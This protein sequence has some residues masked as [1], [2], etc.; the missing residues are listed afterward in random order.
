MMGQWWRGGV[1]R[2][3]MSRCRTCGSSDDVISFDP[4]GLWAFFLRRTWCP[5]HC[6][7][8]DYQRWPD[9]T[10]CNNCGQEPPWDYYT[11]LD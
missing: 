7:D 9:G 3:L 2:R 8:H 10:Y 11:D 4:R 1:A 5:R 6:P